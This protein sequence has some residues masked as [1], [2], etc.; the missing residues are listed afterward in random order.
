MLY[1]LVAS[2][3][4]HDLDVWAYLRDVLARLAVT[5]EDRSPLTTELL[6]PLWPDVWAQAQP[7][8]I[9][10]YR[11]HESESRAAAKRARREKR[12]AITA[13]DFGP[14]TSVTIR[15]LAITAEYSGKIG[16]ATTDGCRLK[17]S[18]AGRRRRSVLRS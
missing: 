13:R 16:A 7:E 17:P 5:R 4:R 15:M 8:A 10:S 1:T 18:G 11:Q 2:A 9:R 6:A 14:G 3:A 12:R